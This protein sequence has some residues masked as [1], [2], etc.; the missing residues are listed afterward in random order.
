YDRNPV[1]LW[2]HDTAQL[3]I[4]RAVPGERVVTEREVIDVHEFARH[5]QAKV[6]WELVAE[7]FV[8]A[9][10]VRWLPG[11]TEVRTIGGEAV[12]VFTRG[13]EHELLE[14][15]YVTVPADPG[16][17]VVRAGGGRLFELVNGERRFPGFEPAPAAAGAGDPARAARRL[18][19]AAEALKMLEVAHV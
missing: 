19:E 13:H 3:P 12:L 15:S 7:G 8:S 1:V 10:S 6:T 5:P 4:A 2:N 11:E 16:A 18:R 17:L 14:V 9:T